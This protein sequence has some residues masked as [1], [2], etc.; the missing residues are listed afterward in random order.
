[1]LLC[2][3]QF[4][5]VCRYLLLLSL[6][7][8]S[9]RPLPLL[10][11][12]IAAI[13]LLFCWLFAA[14]PLQ[15]RCYLFFFAQ[16]C[17]I[18]APEYGNLLQAVLHAAPLIH[19]AVSQRAHLKVT[20]MQIFQIPAHWHLAICRII[21]ASHLHCKS[22]VVLFKMIVRLHCKQ[23]RMPQPATCHASILRLTSWS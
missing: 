22:Q 15:L 3:C 11:R 2:G 5:A 8:S 17:Q 10:C 4:A 12:H 13:V 14:I 1:M 19:R 6:N 7:A 23:R 9:C 20:P 16:L 21:L 18:S